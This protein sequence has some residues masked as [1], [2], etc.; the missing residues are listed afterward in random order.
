M[1]RI[2]LYVSLLL[3]LV[4]CSDS[5]IDSVSYHS[6]ASLW[7]Y[8]R[9]GTVQITEDIYLCGTVVAND[10]RG[11]LNRAIVVMDDSAGL[12]V[13][14]DMEALYEV[15]PL[16]SRVVIRCAGL[17]LG[18]IGPKLILGAEP[19]G[20]YVV[21]RVD[22]SVAQ[23]YVIP[24]SKGGDAPTPRRRRVSA[25]GHR[26]MLN[27]VALEDIRLVDSEHGLRWADKDSTTNQ[28]RTTVRH[29]CQD[30]DTLR[31]VIDADC[32]YAT[33]YIPTANLLVSGILDWY[34]G[35]MALRIIAHSVEP[36]Y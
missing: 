21:D 18:A 29:F 5:E 34:G 20:S 7:S 16:Y 35:D 10:K 33:E 23:N 6:I 25:L 31:V 32:N 8:V 36:R 27:Y 15:Y 12:L 22:A 11:E 14:I 17:W 4:G 26:D 19:I 24:I 2:V 3:S 28:F 9:Q 1:R 30:G 13:E